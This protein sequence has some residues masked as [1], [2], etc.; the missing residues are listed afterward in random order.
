MKIICIGR[1]YAEH[2]RELGNDKPAEPVLFL[3][4]ETAL[5]TGNRSVLI[6]PFTNDL[7]HEA[8]LVVQI[9]R[10][11]K[12]IPMDEALN[13]IGGLA[14]GIDF[15]ARDLQARLKSASLPWEISKAFDDSAPVSPFIPFPGPHSS[16][17]IQFSLRVNGE[18]RQQGN[19]AQMI[20]PF[21]EIIHFASRFFRLLP[22]DMIFTGT[23]AGVSAV[24]PGDHLEG[25]IFEDKLLDFRMV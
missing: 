1:N 18:L 20:F 17:D 16:H 25:Y 12:N 5:V 19:T 2:I 24:K 7:H 9:S 15:T 10:E 4:P 13:Y 22:G 14:L 8:E 23:P 3:K 11:G 6:P 21:A